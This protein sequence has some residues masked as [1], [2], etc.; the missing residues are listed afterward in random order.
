M[1]MELLA[2]AGSA[3]ALRAAVQSGA[4]AVYLGGELFG[5][6][7][8]AEN[9]T[10]D[11]MREWVE[12]CHL[13]GIDVHVTVNTLVKEKELPAFADYIRNLAAIGVDALIVQDLGAAEL[14][15]NIV[16]DMVLHASTQM[17][18]TSLEGVKYLENMGFSRVV[19][20]RE[21]SEK[22]I[23][24]ICK[25]A[26]SEIEVF[27]HGAI[28]MSYSGQCLMSS[29]L[30]GR[31]G[32][33]GRCA[34]PCRLPYELIE[35]D[36]KVC[37][38]YLLSPKDMALINDLGTLNKIG[39]KSLKIEGRL[40]RAE[41]VSAV[42]GIYRKYLD[43]DGNVSKED[44]RELLNAFSRTG[45]TDGYFKGN[46]GK[47]M[48]SHDT[49]GNSSDNKF[50]D[51]ARERAAENANIRKIPIGIM[52]TLK[53]NT[54]LEL[55][56]YD[57]DGHYAYAKGT[58][59]AE[60]AQKTA[61]DEKRLISQ[62]LKL[63]STPFKCDDINVSAGENITLPIKEIN[64]VRREAAEKLICERKK[65]EGLQIKDF[66]LPMQKKREERKLKITAE[67]LCEDQ[68]KMCIEKG[69]ETIY[70]PAHILGTLKDKSLLNI[71]NSRNIE[72]ITKASEIFREEKIITDKVLVSSP[73]AIYKYHDRKIMGDFRLNVYNSM[74][75]E[76]FK[77]LCGI[78][79]SPELNLHEINDLL[80]NTNMK[81]EVI[82]YGRLP[83]MIMRNCP[84]KAAGFCQENGQSFRLRDRKREE[85]PI[86]CMN[87]CTAKLLNSK[88]VFMADK[89][90]DLKK[91]KIDSIRLIFTVEKF[92]QCGKI[93]DVY[94]NALNGK[95]AENF[96]E[97]NSFTRGHF[98]RG[99]M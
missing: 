4:D 32:N 62:L 79:L 16:P 83:L 28:C 61:L 18:V 91:L 10:M 58:L 90:D 21:L 3:A 43:N 26:K 94:R 71:A 13:Y 2:P 72:I 57:N 5:A 46:L 88:P 45:F 37:D 24:H 75:A 77:E 31:S 11:D 84:I 20:A 51:A 55:T 23:E 65:R 49:P 64:A 82:V 40:K 78:T 66:S 85:F 6:R 8:S 93:I 27:V 35:K 17:T 19:L 92:L 73:A 34:Q 68:L 60:K 95:T 69:I 29:I 99:V 59:N 47:N 53:D 54:P 97:E 39:V 56:F 87:G 15:K 86:I 52:G 96:M 25:N 33:R 50:T 14:I 7:H 98:Y 36:K 74:T 38:G 67:V 1:S 41:Y 30:G 81:A 22:E 12:Y 44:M 70:V 63:G 42:V 48:M 76:H 80:L 89:L 9:F